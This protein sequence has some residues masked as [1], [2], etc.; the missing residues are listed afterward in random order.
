[1]ALR[2]LTHGAVWAGLLALL[3]ST[4]VVGASPQN[5]PAE[6]TTAAGVYSNAQAERGSSTFASRCTGC[7][8]NRSFSGQPFM[9]TW[10]GAT[11]FELLD[12]LTQSMPEDAPG[13]LTRDEYV[14][15][16]AYLLKQNQ[17]PAGETDLPA[18]P[19]AL[20]K[21]RLAAGLRAAPSHEP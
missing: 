14:Q 8:T 17:M 19:E 5:P 20:K 3:G 16:I 4:L 12:F 9:T 2:S 1:M 7:H 13:S 10:K 6:R 15:V 18:D 21:I 11:L